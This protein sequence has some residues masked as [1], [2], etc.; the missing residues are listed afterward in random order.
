MLHLDLGCHTDRLLSATGPAEMTRA[1][2][3]LLE[4]ALSAWRVLTG[5]PSGIVPDPAIPDPDRWRDQLAAMALNAVTATDYLLV[6]LSTAA[7]ARRWRFPW[8]PAAARQAGTDTEASN[9]LAR[10]RLD[11]RAEAVRQGARL[12]SALRGGLAGL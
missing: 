10:H 7:P 9:R 12:G 2:Q 11:A 8:R 1:A 4:A 6:L 3:D 5:P